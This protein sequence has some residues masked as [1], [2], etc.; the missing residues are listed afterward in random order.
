MKNLAKENNKMRI[1]EY[2]KMTQ[3]GL[4]DEIK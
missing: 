4:I 1:L 2:D 3:M